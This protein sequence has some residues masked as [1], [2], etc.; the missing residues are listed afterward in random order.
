MSTGGFRDR[1]W[2]T[3]EDTID[4]FS[5][6]DREVLPA[7]AWRLVT[8]GLA[9]AVDA[10]MYWSVGWLI[11]LLDKSSP[12]ALLRDHWLALVG[13]LFLIL[14]VRAVIMIA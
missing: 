6:T 8:G 12:A 1:I 3:V 13:L 4:P 11:D 14:V 9:G 2:R 10:A 7:D 5:D